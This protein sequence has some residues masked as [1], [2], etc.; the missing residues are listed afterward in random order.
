[1]LVH[2][3][4]RAPNAELRFSNL[5]VVGHYVLSARQD[6]EDC[7]VTDPD[8]SKHGKDDDTEDDGLVVKKILSQVRDFKC[9]QIMLIFNRDLNTLISID[10][11]GEKSW[12]SVA[13]LAEIPDSHLRLQYH[14][15]H[16]MYACHGSSPMLSCSNDA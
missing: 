8:T 16:I 14:G 15:A 12:S 7:T 13:E 6:K 4:H 10:G 11:N 5:L 2:R 3:Y 1:M 9:E